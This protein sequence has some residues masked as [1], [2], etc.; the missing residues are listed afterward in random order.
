MRFPYMVN[1][2]GTYYKACEDVPMGLPEMADNA[3]D[4][5][6]E[7]NPNGITNTYDEDGNLSETVH[8]QAADKAI[9]KAVETVNED[10][11]PKRGRPAKVE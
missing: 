6:L 1:H 9:Q 4:G 7:M 10:D 11:K 8:T 5:A 2:N 3:P